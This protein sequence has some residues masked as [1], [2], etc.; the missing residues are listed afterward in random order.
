MGAGAGAASGAS[1]W[2]PL[3]VPLWVTR[4]VTLGIIFLSWGY[5]FQP[6]RPCLSVIRA[7]LFVPVN[8]CLLI[9]ACL[10]VLRY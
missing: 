6:G 10:F 2:V 1:L 7:C 4:L 5:C 9:R 8:S 3:S